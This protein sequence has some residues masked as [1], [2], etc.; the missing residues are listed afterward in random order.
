MA[1]KITEIPGILPNGDVYTSLKIES[2]TKTG[3]IT[4]YFDG[5]PIEEYE[6]FKYAYIPNNTDISTNYRYI[7]EAKNQEYMDLLTEYLE[8]QIE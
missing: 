6:S 5:N 4:T 1:I 2:S 8:K 7:S 3:F